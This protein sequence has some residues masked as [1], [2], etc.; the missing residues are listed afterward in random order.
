MANGMPVTS[1]VSTAV[2]RAGI[3]TVYISVSA[4]TPYPFARDP[5]SP[6]IGSRRTYVYR[7]GRSVG[8]IIISSA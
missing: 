7:F 6:G 3:I 5:I 1:N 4:S 2:A 8:Y